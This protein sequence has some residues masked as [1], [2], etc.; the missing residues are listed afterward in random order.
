M[1]CGFLLAGNIC[2]SEALIQV[3]NV[4][5]CTRLKTDCVKYLAYIC[6]INK[7]MYFFVAATFFGD[8]L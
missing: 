5:I 1:A 6:F 4:L 7:A 2:E 3:I 8:I